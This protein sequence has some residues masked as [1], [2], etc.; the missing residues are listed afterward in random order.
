METEHIVYIVVAGLGFLAGLLA[1]FNF[2]IWYREKHKKKNVEEGKDFEKVNNKQPWHIPSFDD[3]RLEERI[4]ERLRKNLQRS[5]ED[6]Q[7]AS[8]TET[9]SNSS[10][11]FSCTS[12][13]M[14]FQP[15]VH[16][17]ELITK[18]DGYTVT[19]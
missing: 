10:N 16:L 12:T 4:V 17:T 7:K 3:K 18:N 19:L 2:Y 6:S 8:D 13:S 11:S 14:L 5:G 9:E 1:L 15:R